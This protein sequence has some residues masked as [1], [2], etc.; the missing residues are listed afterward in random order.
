M[1]QNL[2]GEDLQSFT[3]KARLV[4]FSFNLLFL[5]FSLSLC[6]SISLSTNECDIHVR[7]FSELVAIEKSTGGCDDVAR[8][9]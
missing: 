5:S 8:T 3:T 4:F 1:W 6:L 7:E 9:L 2:Q